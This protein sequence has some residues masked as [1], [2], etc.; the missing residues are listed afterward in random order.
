MAENVAKLKFS[1]TCRREVGCAFR[2][3]LSKLTRI[4][5]IDLI[6]GTCFVRHVAKLEI[7]QNARGRKLR[8]LTLCTR[9]LHIVD[10][11]SS[12]SNSVGCELDE[13][14]EKSRKTLSYEWLIT[15]FS[16]KLLNII[17]MSH[18]YYSLYLA[19]PMIQQQSKLHCFVL[20]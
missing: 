11:V 12:C 4:D 13:I 7:S 6:T 16:V 14:Y 15:P 19:F 2:N 10:P 18:D 3:K 20:I 17:H 8:H 5:G 9:I 1:I